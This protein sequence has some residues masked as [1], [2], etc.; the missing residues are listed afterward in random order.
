[1][2]TGGFTAIIIAAGYIARNGKLK[3]LFPKTTYRGIEETVSCFQQT[4]LV[5]IKVV[6]GN[7]KEDL[8][9]LL[10]KFDAD[11]IINKDYSLGLFSSVLAGILSLDNTKEAFF[12][13]P[14]NKA[15]LKPHTLID[16]MQ[17]FRNSSKGIIHPEC[18]GQRI[19]PP[20]ISTSYIPL[21]KGWQQPGGLDNLLQFYDQDALDYQIS[22]A[23]GKGAKKIITQY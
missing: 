22:P 8:A 19:H 2:A 4:G 7:R 16:M 5:D 11:I 15:L 20:L 6:I 12:V 9:V 14:A 21:I 18:N 23:V 3:P 17:T 13:M 10:N 1:M